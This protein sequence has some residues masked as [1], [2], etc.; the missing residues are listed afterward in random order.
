[1][2]A[3]FPPSLTH[4]PDDITNLSIRSELVFTR[5]VISMEAL[6]TEFLVDRLLLRRGYVSQA[7][8]LLTSFKLVS[9]ALIFWTN[10]ERFANMKADF[11]WIVRI[12]FPTRL[13]LLDY[14]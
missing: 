12:P 2:V 10:F 4:H 8:L 3:E 11:E 9:D 7:H 1:M 13:C 6:Q 14:D 5:L